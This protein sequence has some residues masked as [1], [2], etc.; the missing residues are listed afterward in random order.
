MPNS[1]I[2]EKRLEKNG[3]RQ[4]DKTLGFW[5]HDTRP[6]SFTLIVDDFG[7]KFVGKENADHLISVLK[8]HYE[9]AEDWEGTKYCDITLDWDYIKWKVHLSIPGYCDEAL[10]RS[11]HKLCKIM[12]QPHTHA[13]LVYGA[14][15]QYPK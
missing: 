1:Y 9:V 2:I 8:E 12:D 3:Y 10:I 14:K 5:K 7:V 11:W 4:S 13:L 15:I 6:I